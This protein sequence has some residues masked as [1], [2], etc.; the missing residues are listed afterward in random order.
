VENTE[1][2]ND[3]VVPNLGGEA[4]RK[5]ARNEEGFGTVEENAKRDITEIEEKVDSIV[6]KLQL[7]GPYLPENQVDRIKTK[8]DFI[9]C[10]IKFSN[11]VTELEKVVKEVKQMTISEEKVEDSS[12]K[13]E[14]VKNI[15]LECRSVNEIEIRL[16][17]FQ[18]EEKTEKEEERVVCQLCQTVFKYDISQEQ[19][20]KQSEKLRNLKKNLKAHLET[21]NTRLY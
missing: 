13:S 6:T 8:L 14:D 2:C 5:R 7:E 11:T 4:S 18:Y 15:L 1:D 20:T 21:N 12:K 17:E 19:S 16:P 10:N 3:N 9:K